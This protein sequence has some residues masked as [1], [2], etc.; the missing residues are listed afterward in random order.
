MKN[1]GNKTYGQTI[2]DH[3]KTNRDNVDPRAAAKA[4]MAD[5]EKEILLCIEETLQIPIFKGKDF[6]IKVLYRI[7][8]IGTKPRNLIMACHACPTPTKNQSVWCYRHMSG[9][10]DYFWTLPDTWTYWHMVREPQKYFGDKQYGD[11]LK[12]VHLDQSG[13][14]FNW[15]LKE[16]GNKKD[17]RLSLV[18]KDVSDQMEIKYSDI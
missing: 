16:N 9:G 12:F 1:P 7:E 6:Y 5:L 18:K 2:I 8:K 17:A 11:Q 10:L 3:Y 14:L 15:V 4:W 13:E